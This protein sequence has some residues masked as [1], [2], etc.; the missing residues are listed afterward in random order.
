MSR[1][2]SLRAKDQIQP[3]SIDFERDLRAIEEMV[4]E[5]IDLFR[6]ISVDAQGDSLLSPQDFC[7]VLKLINKYIFNAPSVRHMVHQRREALESG[8]NEVYRELVFQDR[9]FSE[10]V[11]AIVFDSFDIDE[12]IFNNS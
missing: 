11:K 12:E 8:E 9:E 1:P 7:L 3:A 6:Q 5:D 2:P 10:K 4:K